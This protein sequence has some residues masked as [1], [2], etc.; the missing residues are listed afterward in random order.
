M[1]P[2]VLELN[3]FGPY[4][5]K[6]VIDFSF[7]SGSSLFLITGPTGAGKTTVFDAITFALYGRASG[8]SRKDVEELKSHFA[9]PAETCYVK[10]TFLLHGEQYIIERKPKQQR[11]V[12]GGGIST[13]NGDALLTMPNGKTVSGI[14]EV[15][16]RIETLLGLDYN[17]FRQIVM[18]PQGEFKRLLEAESKQK[19][20]IFRK[21]FSTELFNIAEAKLKE[22]RDALKQKLDRV[23]DALATHAAMI[24]SGDYPPLVQALSGS[25][26]HYPSVIGCVDALM[27]QDEDALARVK[28]ELD[29]LLAE[30][31]KT[32]PAAARLSNSRLDR[33]DSLSRQK[34]S[35]DA[36]APAQQS[37]SGRLVLARRAKELWFIERDIQSAAQRA[38]LTE[39]SLPGI[40]ASIDTCAKRLS[41][42][43]DALAA[44]KREQERQ[45]G[46]IAR[47]AGF[48]Q[49][50]QSFERVER[51]QQELATLQKKQ[52]AQAGYV[53][54]IDLLIA[55]FE[56][57]N[58]LDRAQTRTVALENLCAA[59][60]D[61]LSA[62]GEYQSHNTQYGTEFS[63]FLAGQ[64]GVLASR[65]S[66]G[67]PCPVCGSAHHPAPAPGAEDVPTEAALQTLKSQTD[68]LY[69]AQMSLYGD[70]KAYAA[71]L[72][73][74]E[75]PENIPSD[76]AL[77][78]CRNE[79][80]A[81]YMEAKSKRDALK[82][83]YDAICVRAADELL[84]L[85]MADDARLY[86]PDYLSERKTQIER[87]S[88]SVAQ[89]LE[90]LV[91]QAEEV[92]STIP[93][94]MKTPEEL[95]AQ[96]KQNEL[97][98]ERIEQ[99]ARL[100]QGEFVAASG[101]FERLSETERGAKQQLAEAVRLQKD[102][103]Q[104]LLQRLALHGFARWEDA[105][106]HL[107][108]DEQYAALE[109]E[110]AAYADTLAKTDAEL[111]VLKKECEGVQ[112]ID[113]AAVEKRLEALSHLIGELDAQKTA[114]S[115]RI[116]ANARAVSR[117]RAL[118][119]DAKTDE[120]AY[121][122][123]AALY[124]LAKGD[125]AA[126]IS[127]ER[128]VLGAYFSDVIRA[129][130]HWLHDM[131]GGKYILRH[132]QDRLKGGAAA[133]LDLAV[134]DAGTG[135]ERTVGT[136][137]GGESFKA[138]L[139]LALGLADVIQS[140]SGGV[141]IET[142]FIDEGFGSLDDLSRERAVDT[143]F[144][145]E[146][147]GRLIGIISHVAELKERIP[148]RLEVHTTTKGSYALFV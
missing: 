82:D 18:L 14:T 113:V 126:K 142:M 106:S 120:T 60:A 119:A 41:K 64:A 84:A 55:R 65:L 108:T 147:T 36:Q 109:A 59:I 97:E 7:L 40:A 38:A 24:Q 133:G 28:Q 79:L 10:L 136:L 116:D 148:A 143:L 90:Q 33:M 37:R 45:A 47:R 58:R 6:Q 81:L 94:D 137:S 110:I 23:T 88:A 85:N 17:Q 121:G 57:K 8:E 34:V 75:C 131:T 123:V 13:A 95:L 54:T 130:N 67:V 144:E 42:A 118:L 146:K 46:L 128:Y 69:T 138:S 31:G 62:A 48:E 114:L 115:S 22:R 102:K 39:A 101:E 68:K 89:T 96:T 11:V 73:T 20:I 12:R 21:I 30:R 1:K 111:M 29:L 145:L 71:A 53:K 44:T 125:N 99:N 26:L 52:R 70:I 92:R 141:S 27:L 15:S 72:R 51:L 139:A 9:S 83:D 32:D 105:Q 43:K 135:Q 132:K 80:T 77:V 78:T 74:M 16:A 76:D 117:L 49:L 140:Y 61:Y 3:A 56:A 19:Q 25:S 107:L 93:S 50:R 122:D 63:R 112:R 2:L 127:F 91:A 100:A 134:L 103:E 129:A 98:I 5:G 4:A 87:E 104:E 86:D 35:L 124:Q 66:E